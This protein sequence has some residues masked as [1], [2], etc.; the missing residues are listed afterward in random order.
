MGD[1]GEDVDRPAGAVQ[2]DAAIRADQLIVMN[3]GR[4]EQAGDMLRL[5]VAMLDEKGEEIRG[6]RKVIDRPRGDIFALQG[7]ISKTIVSQL[8]VSL[9]PSELQAIERAPTD[10]VEAYTARVMHHIAV[11][12]VR[13]RESSPACECRAATARRWRSW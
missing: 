6:S 9:L 7:E 1:V 3:R 13:G 2:G 8:Q 5:T 10:N 4:V 12:L 11:D